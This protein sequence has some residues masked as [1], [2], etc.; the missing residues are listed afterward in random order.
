MNQH[1]PIVQLSDH[2]ISIETVVSSHLCTGCGAC[3]PVSNGTY[4]MAS[5]ESVGNRPVRIA[6]EASPVD[7]SQFCPG[8][9]LR[10]TDIPSLFRTTRSCLKNG[11]RPVCLGGVRSRSS[12]ST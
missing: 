9:Y 4:A 1:I 5:I 7:V 11:A 8:V 3:I 12:S 2:P 10:R 6:A